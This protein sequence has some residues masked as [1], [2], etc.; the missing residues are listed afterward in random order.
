MYPNK[1]C[2]Y[3]DI[4]VKVKRD[5]TLLVSTFIIDFMTIKDHCFAMV[6]INDQQFRNM[7]KLELFSKVVQCFFGN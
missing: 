3:N 7:N 1:S 6:L 4:Y 5:L 2:F